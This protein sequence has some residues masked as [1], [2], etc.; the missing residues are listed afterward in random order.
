MI[1]HNRIHAGELLAE[2][3]SRFCNQNPLILGIPRGALP[4]AEVLQRKL[5]GDLD[6]ILVH[7]V[8]APDH[9]EFAIG[10][11]SE[12]GDIYRSSAIED[13][14]ISAHY[15]E[16]AARG[17]LNHLKARRQMYSPLLKPIHAKDRTVLLVDDGIATGAT[18]LSAIRAVRFMSPKKI[19]CVA[20]VISKGAME[21]IKNEADEVLVLDQPEEFHSISQFYEDFS[22]VSDQE[23][24]RILKSH[25]LKKEKNVG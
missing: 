5:G 3:L 15:F 4:I 1:F 23:V 11:I 10:S 12:W 14:Q 13:Y 21:L 19:I 8:G 2:K 9:P 22:Q 7:K 18:I 20:P 16:E 25:F 17:E 6:V 24:I